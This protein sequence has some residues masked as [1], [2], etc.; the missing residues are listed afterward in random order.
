MKS[1]CKMSTGDLGAIAMYL[2]GIINQIVKC[3]LG[4]YAL[5]GTGVLL[6]SA[7]AVAQA[8]LQN[9]GPYQGIVPS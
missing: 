4:D 7:L 2:F 1:G 8:L 3:S 6:N 9:T 5:I